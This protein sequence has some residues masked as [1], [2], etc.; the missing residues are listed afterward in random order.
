MNATQC[1]SRIGNNL[2]ISEKTKRYAIKII[3]EYQQNWDI[4][5][6]SPTGIAATSIYL[7]CIKMNEKFS[8]KEV[9]DAANI[10]EVTIRNRSNSIKRAL[11]FTS[12]KSRNN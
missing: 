2:G 6:K 10:T 5:G 4:A 8:Q 7:A 12:I 9:A 11:N 1:V 3:N